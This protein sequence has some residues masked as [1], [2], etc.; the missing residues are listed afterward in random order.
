M[1]SSKPGR[2]EIANLLSRLT[3]SWLNG[4][5]WKA[6]RVTLEASDL[7]PLKQN[8]TSALLAPKFRASAAATLSLLWRLY[9]FFK[10]DLLIQG[11][12]ALVTSIAIFILPVLMRLI[13]RYLESPDSD[14]PYIPWICVSGLLLCGLLAALAECQCN[15]IGRQIGAKLRAILISEIYDKV[16]RKRIVKSPQATLQSEPDKKSSM[17]EDV[18]DGNILNLISVDVEVIVETSVNLHLVWVIFPVQTILGTY[19][20]YGILGISGVFGVLVMI[21]LIPLNILVSKHMAQIQ[22]YVLTASDSRIQASNKLLQNIR[23]IKYCAWESHFREQIL[24]KRRLEIKQIRLR[25][26]WWSISMTL[27]QLLPFVLVSATFFLY[28]IFWG[29]NLDTSVAFP[30]LVLLNLLRIPLN[31]MADSVNIILRAHVSL[32][33]IN[34]FLQGQ[35]SQKYLQ[36]PTNHK[37]VIGFDDATF[38]WS[39]IR[40]ADNED[41]ETIGLME[42][43]PTQSFTLR[44]LQIRFQKNALNVICGQSGSGKSS[45]LLALLGEMDLIRG[46]VFFPYEETDHA[47]IRPRGHRNLLSSATAYC[48]QEPWIINQSIRANIL[49][50]MSLNTARYRTVLHAVALLQDFA[51]LS[52]GDQTLAGENGCRLSGGQKQRV[53]LA[54]A[55]Y[56]NSKYVLIDDSLSAL[57][58]HT[59]N[60]IF[61]HAIRGSLMRER[62]CIFAT[63]NMQLAV[64]H[65]KHVVILHEGEVKAQGTGEELMASGFISADILEGKSERFEELSR[66]FKHLSNISGSGT[67]SLAHETLD[68]DFQNENLVC[69]G[70]YEEN[71]YEGAV[72]WSIIKTYMLT[73]GTSRYWIIVLLLFAAQQVSSLG[74]ILWIK[75]WAA[76]YDT[77]ELRLTPDS[78]L[79]EHYANITHAVSAWYYLAIYTIIWVSYA[80]ISLLRNFAVFHGSIKASSQIYERL[81]DSILHTRLFF[82]DSVPLG[83]IVNRFSRDIEILDQSLAGFSISGFELAASLAMVIVL[84]SIALPAFLLIAT[85]LFVVY[86]SVTAVYIS[87]ARDFKRIEAVARSPLYQHFGETLAGYTSIRAYSRSS[88]FKKENHRLLDRLNQPYLHQ[89]ASMGWLRLRIG[90][91]S[92]AIS[93]S[94]GALI[95]WKMESISSNSAGLI[96]TYTTSF[97]ENVMWLVQIYS[98][99]QQDLVSIERVMEYT[100]IVQEPTDPLKKSLDIIPYNWPSQGVVRFH[101]Y[102]TRYGQGLEPS[103]KGIDFEVR[104]GQRIAIVGR[105]G[106]GKTT[107]AL[108]LIRELEA[109]SGHIEID[110]IDISSITLTRL[111]QAVTIIPQDPKLF[112]ESLRENL[113]PPNSNTDE[114]MIEALR[115][116]HLLGPGNSHSITYSDLDRAA[117]TLSL[118]QRQLLCIARGLLRRSRVLLLDEAT[119][120]VDHQTDIAIQAGLRMSAA[121]GTTILVIAHRLL[122]IADYDRVVVLSAG[123][124]VEQGSIQRL[125]S[126]R[127]KDAVF[128]QMC[129][130]SGDI[131][132]I[133]R[134]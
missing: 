6:F 114:E 97:T 101:N 50:G 13:L 98:I 54:R 33:R 9:H 22:G 96:L 134:S 122:S 10:Y 119:A 85:V 92:S 131:N 63:H 88:M 125:L 40:A 121:A 25:F 73:M 102:T 52:Q 132:E 105:T 42:M 93:F 117:N 115:A 32:L 3:F 20:L 56:S 111:R 58:P 51:E 67:S 95:V 31:R 123:R 15:W 120:S 86:C 27:F 70:D 66:P 62:T 74:T 48:P 60:H 49:M 7:Y 4:L 81:L 109:D 127:G 43:L 36:L 113:A 18:S 53:A 108:A 17:K 106:A 130:D 21:L 80:L 99:I 91:L 29:N 64:P 75:E 39:T 16:L 124:V 89:W 38:V 107:L 77:P 133:E 128:R 76:Q 103:L 34:K 55:L 28:T 72:P 19:L 1:L 118:G 30:A 84:I 61:F 45:L 129:E 78:G 37:S 116:V 23:T 5:V 110:G 46:Q 26:V 94:A 41:T 11:A 83:Q 104:A 112:D 87:G 47:W 90:A 100:N 57:D 126:R 14:T 71:K 2:D 8:R 59:A 35:D 24:A 68:M 69:K 82:F 12:W 44:N 65:G 79:L